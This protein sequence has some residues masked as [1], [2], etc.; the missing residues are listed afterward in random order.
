MLAQ[1]EIIKKHITEFVYL[2]IRWQ[3][4]VCFANVLCVVSF[5]AGRPCDAQPSPPPLPPPSSTP[6]PS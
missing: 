3:P 6:P 4:I 2:M 1:F 5:I